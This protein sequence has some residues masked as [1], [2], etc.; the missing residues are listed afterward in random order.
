MNQ[1]RNT[2]KFPGFSYFLYDDEAMDAFLY[3]KERWQDTFPSLHL[4]LQCVNEVH[5]PTL[6]ADIWRYL[7]LWEY[8]GIYADIDVSPTRFNA[9]SINPDDDGF[10]Y[11]ENEAGWLAQFFLASSPHHP[12]MFYAVHAAVQNVLTHSRFYKE[13]IAKITGPR[14]VAEGMATFMDDGSTGRLIEDGIHVGKDGRS[15]RV[16]GMVNKHLTPDGT[17][18]G[19]R[20]VRIYEE[21]NMTYYHK[22]KSE[23]FA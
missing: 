9:S 16:D 21:M 12:L 5:N 17:G 8:G 19:P 3:D 10:F 4:A 1:W 18:Y 6:K 11:I 7:V 2:D 15:I 23:S 20:K 14:A 22:I 13:D